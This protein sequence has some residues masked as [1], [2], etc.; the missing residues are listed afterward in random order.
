MCR[1]IDSRQCSEVEA[2]WGRKWRLLEGKLGASYSNNL[3]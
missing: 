1:W 2:G 3:F